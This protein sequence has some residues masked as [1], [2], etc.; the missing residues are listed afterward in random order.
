M[1]STDFLVKNFEFQ[2][3]WG[4]SEKVTIFFFFF[5]FFFW[6]GGGGGGGGVGGVDLCL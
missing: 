3:L 1:G 4:V 2:F 6:G 5:F